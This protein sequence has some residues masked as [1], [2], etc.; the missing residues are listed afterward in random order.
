MVSEATA[1]AAPVLTDDEALVAAAIEDR[2]RFAALYERY[3]LPVYRYL[4]ARGADDDDAVELAAVTFERALGSLHNFR[5]RR[6]GLAA[7]PFRIARNAKIDERRRSVRLAPLTDAAAVQAPST[8]LEGG[9]DLRVLVARL[10]DSTR[11]AIALR[12]GAGLTARE[13]GTVLGKHPE[14]VQKLIERGLEALREAF[15]DPA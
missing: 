1:G 14:A 11:D 4:R 12:Y 15:R 10:P 3:R 9:L 5:P 8:D 13:I 2:S 6:G 7:W